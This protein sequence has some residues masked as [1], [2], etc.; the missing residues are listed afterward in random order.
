MSKY[1]NPAPIEW[2]VDSRLRTL[3]GWFS[4]PLRVVKNVDSDC[5]YCSK[6]LKLRWDIYSN[7]KRSENVLS[8]INDKMHELSYNLMCG[9]HTE[10]VFKVFESTIELQ[11]SNAVVTVLVYW[12]NAQNSIRNLVDVHKVLSEDKCGRISPLIKNEAYYIK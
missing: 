7:Y 11:Q 6:L 8:A 1:R 9:G 5:I 2:A 4:S 10:Y 3:D 12:L